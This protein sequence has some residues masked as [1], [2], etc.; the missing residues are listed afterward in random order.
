MIASRCVAA[1]VAGLTAAAGFA[2]SAAS[3]AAFP[4]ACRLVLPARAKVGAP[5][6]L[7]FELSNRGT[8]DV[9][10][11]RWNTP[12]EGWLGNYL[13]VA[14]A[15]GDLPYT[16]PQ[17]KRGGAGP[18]RLHPDSAGQIG[19]RSRR[20]RAGLCARPWRVPGD[21]H[22]PTARRYGESAGTRAI[23]GDF[24]M[25]GGERPDRVTGA[26]QDTGAALPRRRVIKLPDS[27]S[28]ST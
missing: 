2:A 9:R 19:R 24:V 7:R 26:T 22:R 28:Q 16:G 27:L 17:V 11:M 4:L 6:P 23:V 18:R 20:P 15:S 5:V 3:G 14:G 12:L 21:L 13:T 25:S 8:R 10:V 1:A